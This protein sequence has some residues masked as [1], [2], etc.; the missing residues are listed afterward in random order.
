MA[1]PHLRG[2]LPRPVE[3][4]RRARRWVTES[5]EPRRHCLVAPSPRFTTPT[6]A[7]GR[8]DE[9]WGVNLPTPNSSAQPNPGE[10]RGSAREDLVE[11]LGELTGV[12]AEAAVVAG[13]GHRRGAEALGE[14]DGRAVSELTHRGLADADHDP[15]RAVAQG[16]D[17]GGVAA[18]LPHAVGEEVLQV[19]ADPRPHLQHL[20]GRLDLPE[21]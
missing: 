7:G 10:E 11:G 16:G 14:G 5:R 20:G 17:V 2:T 18:D 21:L 4:A 12:A 1:P 3:K 19:A 13:E 8:D 15:G 9:G 6:R